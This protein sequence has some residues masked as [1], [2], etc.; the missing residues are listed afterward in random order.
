METFTDILEA[1]PGRISEW[2]QDHTKFPVTPAK[3]RKFI[4]LAAARVVEE[5]KH[6][7]ITLYIDHALVDPENATTII[8]PGSRRSRR[9]PGVTGVAV[10]LDK[11]FI[12]GYSN[13]DPS[14]RI[15]LWPLSG[16]GTEIHIECHIKAIEPRFRELV[17]AIKNRWVRKD[18]LGTA[19]ADEQA[20]TIAIEIAT[21]KRPKIVRIP[22]CYN[23]KNCHK[24][25]MTKKKVL[26]Y[27]LDD[28]NWS[29]SE[30]ASF[31]GTT[32]GNI[33]KHKRQLGIPHW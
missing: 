1:P 19:P 29:Q 27:Y 12:T 33:K 31:T 17:D 28:F 18:T 5:T 7:K 11:L 14:F 21:Y 25:G 30:V 15:R 26:A 13:D 2:L 20:E 16:R 10:N 23:G 22:A 4:A 32:K 8:E 6:G 24:M 3:H 9:N